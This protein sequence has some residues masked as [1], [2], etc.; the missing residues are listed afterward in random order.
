MGAAIEK[1]WNNPAVGDALDLCLSCKGC[2]RDCP[3]NVD[4]AT[5]KA[6]FRSHYYENKM[7]PRSAYSM[8]LVPIWAKAA[9]HAPGLVNAAAR[10]GLL[11]ALGKFVAGISQNRSIPPFAPITYT[12]WRRRN[13]TLNPRGRRVLLFPDTFNNY[14]RPATP[15]RR[16]SS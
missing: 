9:S 4:M 8:G 7:R 15:S 1:T 14:F 11:G 6:E 3:V 2:K 13:P 16:Q 12:A 10:N 5:Y